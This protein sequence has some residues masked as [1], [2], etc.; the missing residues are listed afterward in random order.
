MSTRTTL[1]ALAVMTSAYGAQ[2]ATLISLSDFGN[3]NVEDFNAAPLGFIQPT[4]TLFSD[5]GITGIR[6]THNNDRFGVRANSS[7]ALGVDADGNLNIIDPGTRGLS[8]SYTLSFADAITQFGFGIHDQRTRL[9]LEFF[10]NGTIV[11]TLRVR[12]GTRDLAQFY[13][14]AEEFN[15]VRI[16]SSRS[17]QAFALDNLTV[18]EPNVVPV[19]AGLPLFVTALGA[20]AWVRRSKAKA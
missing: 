11:D 2:A 1:A 15:L 9:T 16:S 14:R 17:R 3:A 10:N 13:V 6:A 18:G 5:L 4:D 8:S 12:T 19:P 7:R 20:F